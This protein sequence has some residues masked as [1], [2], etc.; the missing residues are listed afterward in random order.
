MITPKVILKNN[1]DINT[2][3]IVHQKTSNRVIDPLLENKA[4]TI[5]KNLLKEYQAK[6]LH[7]WDGNYYR[8]DNPEE[9]AKGDTKL[10]LSTIHFSTLQ[11]YKV[12]SEEVNLK[13]SQYSNFISTGGLIKTSDNFYIFGKRGKT[14]HSSNV[15]IIGGGLLESENIVNTGKDIENNLYKEMHEEINILESDVNQCNFIG[16]LHNSSMNILFIFRVDLKLSRSEMI[17]RFNNR[18]DDE[19]SEL[20]FIEEKNI[21]DFL[22]SLPSYRPLI[23]ELI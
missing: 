5:W 11:A 23:L 22:F 19:M 4:T 9:V 15:D 13:E 10:I 21:K 12:I 6:G 14:I 3:K 17:D 18:S 1:L 20:L 8:L 16:I 7:I 2:F